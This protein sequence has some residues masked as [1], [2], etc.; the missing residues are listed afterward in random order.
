[1]L[2]AEDADRALRERSRGC[3][4]GTRTEITDAGRDWATGVKP[5]GERPRFLD[6]F[7][8]ESRVVW[9]C[10]VAGA[11]K[12]SI[13]ITWATVLDEMGLL[14]SLYSFQAA[15]Q[16]TLNPTNL[17]STITRQLAQHNRQWEQRLINIIHETKP[18]ARATSSP[19]DQF[20]NF[21]LG[22]LAHDNDRAVVQPTVIIIDAFDECGSIGSRREILDILTR[23]AQELPAGIRIIVTSRYEADV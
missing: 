12:S 3:L 21:L 14:G 8:P 11:G 6:V 1:M 13:A 23:R 20:E 2:C 19:S 4:F 5:Q 10:G 18:N 22:V 17:F 7:D 9:L 15:K 16:A